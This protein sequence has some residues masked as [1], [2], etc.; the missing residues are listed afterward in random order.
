VE[1]DTYGFW[2]VTF[3]TKEEAY[4]QMEGKALEYEISEEYDADSDETHWA[5]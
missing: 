4:R 3:T 2:Y 5:Q 1:W